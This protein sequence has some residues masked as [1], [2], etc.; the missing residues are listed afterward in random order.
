MRRGRSQ[1][2]AASARRSHRRLAERGA[3]RRPGFG[4]GR[5]RRGSRRESRGAAPRRALDQIAEGPARRVREIEDHAERDEAVHQLA[6]ESREPAVALGGTVGKGVASI[7]RQSRPSARRARRTRRP[8]RSRRRSTRPPR[9]RASARFARPARRHRGRPRSA[10][11]PTGRGSLRAPG[12]TTPPGR[13]PRG[14][15]PP[16]GLR[17]RSRSGTPAT[18][19]HP[20]REAEA[21]FREDVGLSQAA[22]AVGELHQQVD[23][24]VGDHEA[25]VSA[26]L[27]DDAGRSSPLTTDGPGYF[28][29][30]PSEQTARPRFPPSRRRLPFAFLPR[31]GV[32]TTALARRTGRSAPIRRRCGGRTSGSS[33]DTSRARAVL[34]GVDCGSHRV[35]ARHGLVARRRADRPRAAVRGRH[36]RASEGRPAERL[37]R[38][39]RHR[40]RRSASR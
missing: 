18:R 33:C 15:T 10:P 4:G 31:D 40:R 13:G 21:M 32:V 36:H 39:G 6:A 37:A 35:D 3:D 11:G 29:C 28:V 14:A 19:P 5:S 16:A 27:G 2:G 26:A 20:R 25:I 7:P 24:K 38:A 8:A 1:A 12:E 30:T 17:C 22:L 23:V 34:A 9:A